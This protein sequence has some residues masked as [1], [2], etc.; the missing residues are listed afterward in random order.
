MREVS[1]PESSSE[2]QRSRRTQKDRGRPR[3]N[4][5]RVTPPKEVILTPAPE[6][7]EAEG[8]PAVRRG[9]DEDDIAEVEVR[10]V[11]RSNKGLR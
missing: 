4:M 3:I 5:I 2:D 6:W 8:R 10:F 7:H 9:K 11:P 1:N